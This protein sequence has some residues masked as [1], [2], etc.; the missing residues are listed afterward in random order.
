M[1]RGFEIVFRE[2]RLRRIH[3]WLRNTFGRPRR[4]ALMVE[5]DPAALDA[6]R[7]LLGITRKNRT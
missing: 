5:P 7:G 1:Q 2:K 3:R 4:F 6:W